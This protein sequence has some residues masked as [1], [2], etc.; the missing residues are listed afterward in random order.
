MKNALIIGIFVL[1]AG[2]KATY[3]FENKSSFAV[4]VMP[5]Y[6]EDFQIQ[7]GSVKSFE[8]SH[9]DMKLNY[10]PG[11][12][13]QT[14]EISP[15]HW[16]FSNGN[17]FLEENRDFLI[18]PPE[19]WQVIDYPGLEYKA[20][21]GPVE[22]AF[23]PNINFVEE[24]NPFSS[25]FTYADV[26]ANKMRE[27]ETRIITREKFTT[28]SGMDGIK[29]ETNTANLL[30]VYYLFDTGQRVF[31]I[32]CSAPLQSNSDYVTIFDNSVKTLV[33]L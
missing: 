8:S 16:E 21:I 33:F 32:T 18:Y 15:R 24:V 29:I 12:Y 5:E 26:A 14:R 20:I 2:C 9:K 13:V 7:A 31:I 30:Q 1:L 27:A 23:A 17:F 22:N 28:V 4:T 25:L 10:N 3:T 11:N 6:G 19:S